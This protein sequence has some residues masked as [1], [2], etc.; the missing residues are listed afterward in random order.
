MVVVEAHIR[1]A[2]TVI[3]VFVDGYTAVKQMLLLAATKN[4]V[5]GAVERRAGN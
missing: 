1:V 3:V 5:D 4:A 2:C